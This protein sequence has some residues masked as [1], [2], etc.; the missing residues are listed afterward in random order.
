MS[1]EQKNTIISLITS[2]IVSVPYYIYVL[3]KYQSENLDS[4]EAFK[5]WATAILWIIPIRIVIEILIHI[6]SVIIEAIVTQKEEV[7]I[8]D[9]RDKL[10]SLKATRNAYYS[11]I[12]SFLV[13]IGTLYSDSKPEVMFITLI[14]GGFFAEL[15]EHISKLFYYKRGY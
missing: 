8:S 15:V 6:V 1:H 10:I 12:L 7:R 5:F 13:A 4:T 14:I 9:E 2:V 3:N 11:F